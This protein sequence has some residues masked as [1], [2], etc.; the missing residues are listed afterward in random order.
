LTSV[1]EEQ[2][3]SIKCKVNIKLAHAYVLILK[4]RKTPYMIL[5]TS[6][7]L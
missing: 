1:N 4:E 6:Y 7:S 2:R 5:K 3:L